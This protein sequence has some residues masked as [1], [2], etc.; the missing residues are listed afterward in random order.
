MK[1][2]E[3]RLQGL[4]KDGKNFLEGWSARL[5]VKRR[6][7]DMIRDRKRNLLDHYSPMGKNKAMWWEKLWGSWKKDAEYTTEELQDGG[8]HMDEATNPGEGSVEEGSFVKPLLGRK[9][10]KI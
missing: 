4:E 1:K 10:M 8:R 2:G 7:L 5:G 3:K 6:A 9:H